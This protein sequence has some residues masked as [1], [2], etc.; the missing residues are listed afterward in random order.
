MKILQCGMAR[1]LKVMMASLWMVIR[2]SAGPKSQ[3]KSLVDG[4]CRRGGVA[5]EYEFFV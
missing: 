4:R 2:I 1:V 5:R 3:A